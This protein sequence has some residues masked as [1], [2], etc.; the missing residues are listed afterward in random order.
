MSQKKFGGKMNPIYALTGII[1][2][3]FSTSIAYS[4]VSQ[5]THHGWDGA[6]QMSNGDVALVIVPQ[7]GGRI[8]AYSLTGLDTLFY[9]NPDEFGKLYPITPEPWHNYGGYKVW[10]APQ[11][12][13][14][15]PPDPWLD[16][17]PC[18]IQILNP[19][20]VRTVGAPSFQTGIV[21]TRE[22]EMA[23]SGSR[24][25]IAQTMTNITDHTVEWSVWDVTQ[26]QRPDWIVFS[27]N[28]QSIFPNGINHHNDKSR[29]SKGWHV[30]GDWIYINYLED[31]GKLG[32]DSH[33]GWIAYAKDNQIY[34]KT[35]PVYAD[36]KYPHNGDT[37]EVYTAEKYIEVEVLSPL[38]TL[39]PGKS[40]TFTEQWYLMHSEQDLKNRD[41]LKA[42][43]KQLLELRLKN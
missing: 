26:L 23:E 37:V 12:R 11:D 18:S 6:Y 40:Y 13:W 30:E 1:M 41:N 22:I 17:G 38:V 16:F 36:Q 43:V 19:L 32:A 21:Y 14:G 15:W 2:I 7:I 24:V 10:N 20:K 5:T 35:F 31:G 4:D 42:T 25:Q 8:M 34:L 29:E 9:Q 28:I 27:L 3:W 33:V 39:G